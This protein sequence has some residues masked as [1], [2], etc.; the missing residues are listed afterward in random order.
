MAA[1]LRTS[2]AS[3]GARFYKCALQVNFARSSNLA[4]SF[5]L[6][7]AMPGYPA[8]TCWIKMDA[9]GV[10]G[11]RQAFLDPGSRIL[12]TQVET[13][14]HTELLELN[15]QGGFLDGETIQLNRNLNVLIG[16]RGTGKSTIV[17]SVRSVLGLE[18]AGNDARKAHEGIARHVLRGGTKI[19]LRVRAHR[20]APREY[21]IERTLPNPP[22][23]RDESGEVSH[24]APS[25]LV[26][27]IEVY[28]QNEISELA[29]SEEKLTSLLDRFVQADDTLAM[30]K[31]SLRQELKE[32][33]RVVLE[34]RLEIESTEETLAELPML[35]ET[36]QRFREAGLE[37]RLQDQT[38]LVREERILDSAVGNEPGASCA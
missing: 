38:M 21:T 2:N 23:V 29:R 13:E 22:L 20:P 24:L 27:R 15:W 4:T 11:L 37:E 32:N 9:V 17:E 7:T 33:R 35:E 5:A 3:S 1:D 28:G 26:P 6:T 25:D 8:A 14:G 19:S 12:L 31:A 36:L 10:E 16:G 18:P 34:K 30:R